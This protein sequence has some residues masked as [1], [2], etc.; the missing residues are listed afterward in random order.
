MGG[1]VG[2]KNMAGKLEEA[3]LGSVAT[4]TGRDHHGLKG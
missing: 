2:S 1:G 4:D 3:G